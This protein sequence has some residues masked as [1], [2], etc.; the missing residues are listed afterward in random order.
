MMAMG[1][2]TRGMSSTR[3]TTQRTCPLIK[4]CFGA[5]TDPGF[6]IL[7][8]AD[9]T[10]ALSCFVAEPLSQ[11]RLLKE[12]GK[13]R[14][15]QHFMHSPQLK[16]VSQFSCIWS[17]AI[18]AQAIDISP[19]SN[20]TLVKDMMKLDLAKD[21]EFIP[22]FVWLSPPCETY[23]LLS[24]RSHRNL[25]EGVFTASAKA[26]EHDFLF[27]R[28]TEIMKWIK[29]RN[30]H[31]IFLIENPNGHLKDMPLMKALVEQFGMYPTKVHYCRFGRD[32]QKP[33]M[34]WTNEMALHLRLNNPRFKCSKDTCPFYNKHR[35]QVRGRSDLDHSAIPEFLAE[36]VA[37]YVDAFCIMNNIE[38][39]V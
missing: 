26:N 22:D 4:L 15:S 29:T 37:D 13:V 12:D 25:K 10:G 32:E 31:V 30:P 23:S 27:A 5:R 3:I 24:G 1:M 16:L 35:G 34:L 39:K 21:L 28:M 38:A 6:R 17:V 18:P 8:F 9:P 7:V 2:T 33:T 14:N 19:A 20:A 36:Q 11:Q